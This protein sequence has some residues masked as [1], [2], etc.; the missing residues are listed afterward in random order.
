VL[1]APAKNA[2]TIAGHVV[3]AAPSGPEQKISL[4][5]DVT[6]PDGK[7]LGDVKQANNVPAGSLDGGWGENAGFAA[8][9][10]ATGIFELINKFR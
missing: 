3:M 7:N 6:T 10:A 5:W 9:A 4:R 1:N 2:L 8:E